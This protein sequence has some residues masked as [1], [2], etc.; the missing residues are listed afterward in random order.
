MRAGVGEKGWRAVRVMSHNSGLCVECWLVWGDFAL[1][2]GGLRLIFRRIM[3][4][5]PLQ[6]GAGGGG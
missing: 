2:P 5:E 3:R 4:G 6:V 1:I